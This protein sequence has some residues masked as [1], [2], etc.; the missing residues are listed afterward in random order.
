VGLHRCI[1]AFDGHQ[2]GVEVSDSP[3]IRPLTRPIPSIAHVQLGMMSMSAPPAAAKW[4]VTG[5]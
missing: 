3:P 1:V 2:F 5:W 4:T